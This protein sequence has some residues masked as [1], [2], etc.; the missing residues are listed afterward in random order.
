[1]KN[2]KN[3]NGNEINA[4]PISFICEYFDFSKNDL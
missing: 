3:N 4:D 1:M 2:K